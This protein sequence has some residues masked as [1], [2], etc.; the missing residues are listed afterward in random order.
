MA[1]MT[2]DNLGDLPK[3]CRSC[4]FWELSQQAR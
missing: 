4:V 3:R 1:A 2:L